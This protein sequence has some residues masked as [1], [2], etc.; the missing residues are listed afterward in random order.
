MYIKKVGFPP[1]NDALDDRM[2][3]LKL[4]WWRRNHESSHRNA[5]YLKT[6]LTEMSKEC[7]LFLSVVIRSENVEVP[8]EPCSMNSVADQEGHDVILRNARGV[9]EMCLHVFGCNDYMLRKV[10]Q[11]YTLIV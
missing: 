8:F 3:S 6:S 2:I 10:F 5:F 1:V 11:F 7:I 9:F 4:G